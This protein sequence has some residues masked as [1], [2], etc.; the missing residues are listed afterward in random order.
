MVA[1]NINPKLAE[2][3]QQIAEEQN[4][5]IEEVIA[6]WAE[7]HEAQKPAPLP[8]EEEIAAMVRKVRLDAY[9][10]ARKYWREM[11]NDERLALTDDQL[12]EQFWLFDSEGIPRLKS[13]M[14]Q[15]EIP[16]DSLYRLGEALESADY[17]SGRSDIAAHHK[18]ILRTD[19]T[20]YV[21]RRKNRPAPNAQ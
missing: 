17:H 3:L 8:S 6:V 1:I 15:V 4:L 11:G 18:E 19:Y 14:G 16:E 13:E 9:E 20:D 5:T 21:L 12:D 2:Q 7:K 10:R